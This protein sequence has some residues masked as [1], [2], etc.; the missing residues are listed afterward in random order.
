MGF[1]SVDIMG[2]IALLFKFTVVIVVVVVVSY[3]TARDESSIRKDSRQIIAS[4]FWE[5]YSVEGW[6]T[7]S[8]NWKSSD[9]GFVDRSVE[10]RSFDHQRQT[11]SESLHLGTDRLVVWV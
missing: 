8:L 7:S 6:M 11:R 4:D 9:V 5:S 3:S 1:D 10:C 2:R